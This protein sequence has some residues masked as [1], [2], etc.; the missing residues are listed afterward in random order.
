M[1]DVIYCTSFLPALN[2]DKGERAC[3]EKSN[4]KFT[5][6]SSHGR[7]SNKGRKIK[8]PEKECGEISLSKSNI[9]C[10][11]YTKDHDFSAH[12]LLFACVLCF[13]FFIDYV[14]RHSRI[15]LTLL[16]R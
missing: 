5:G 16:T 4:N 1:Y 6:L 2:K 10:V 3:T 9:L 15:E 8:S 12:K 14:T 13:L 7:P 11:H